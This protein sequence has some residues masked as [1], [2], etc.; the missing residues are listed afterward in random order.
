LNDA[1]G[2][3]LLKVSAGSDTA[4]R[5]AVR[6][7]ETVGQ[8]QRVEAVS[9]DALQPNDRVIVG[10]AHYVMDGQQVRFVQ[11]LESEL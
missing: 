7:L 11:E 9:A 5:V 1:E 10:G 6:P 3:Y 2:S 8:K 4:Q